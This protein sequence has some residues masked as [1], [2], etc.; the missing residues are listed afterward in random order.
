[1]VIDYEQ[2]DECLRVLGDGTRREIVSL[3]ST[4]AM[5]AGELAHAAGVTPP[6]MSRHLRV[7]LAAGLVDDERSVTDA[8]VR[9]FF[10]QR[11]PLEVVRA[12]LGAVIDGKPWAVE[13]EVGA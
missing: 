11:E 6:A 5:R 8:R 10:L 12:W 3:L 9:L 1:V 2:I 4:G 7:L 13:G